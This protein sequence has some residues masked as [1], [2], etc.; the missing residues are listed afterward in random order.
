[1]IKGRPARRAEP[2][3]LLPPLIGEHRRIEFGIPHD[4]DR[5]AGGIFIDAGESHNRQPAERA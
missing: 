5:L 3:D 1:M 4:L 2:G